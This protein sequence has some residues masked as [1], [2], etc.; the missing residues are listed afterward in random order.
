MVDSIKGCA[1]RTVTVFHC[2]AH[3]SKNFPWTAWIAVLSHHRWNLKISTINFEVQYWGA[4]V[5][6]DCIE[7]RAV[8]METV[9]RCTAHPVSASLL[10]LVRS[11]PSASEPTKWLDRVSVGQKNPRWE[12]IVWLFPASLAH[13]SAELRTPQIS[14]ERCEQRE[15][16]KSPCSWSWTSQVS[17]KLWLIASFS[18]Y[19]MRCGQHSLLR[20]GASRCLDAVSLEVGGFILDSVVVPISVQVRVRSCGYAF[21]GEVW[22][23]F[24]A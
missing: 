20:I 9:L 15:R 12:L 1:V 17:A 22:Y 6:V 7:G 16:V 2:S 14:F 3:H 10:D 13:A 24:L 8:Q 19:S 4:L 5:G 23:A 21:R 18:L 11:S